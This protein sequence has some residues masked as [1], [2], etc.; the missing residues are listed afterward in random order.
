M[1]N[2]EMINEIKEIISKRY[3]ITTITKKQNKKFENIRS[4]I[5]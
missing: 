5:I 3:G 1:K 2:E 4:Y